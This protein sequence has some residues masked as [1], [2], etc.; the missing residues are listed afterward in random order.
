MTAPRGSLKL[1]LLGLCA[2]AGCSD[3]EPSTATVVGHFAQD[4]FAHPVTRV[5]VASNGGRNTV[6]PVAS[7]GSFALVLDRGRH[8]LSA[9]TDLGSLP[10]VL[11]GAHGSYAL[12]LDVRGGDAHA[13][14]GAIRFYDPS[15]APY[16]PTD[17]CMTGYFEGSLEPCIT[18]PATVICPPGSRQ[19]YGSSPRVEVDEPMAVPTFSLET[20][21]CKHKRDRRDH[22]DDDWG[23]SDAWGDDDWDDGDDWGDDDWGDDDWG[24]DDWDDW[25]DGDDWDDSDDWDWDDD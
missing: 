3:D 20:F 4:G 17:V 10:L 22:D 13:D 16:A 7:D 8:V 24:D 25:D 6:A 14:I 18:R 19:L 21:G 5:L 15:E 2:L 12:G 11:A 23:D 9:D 1:L